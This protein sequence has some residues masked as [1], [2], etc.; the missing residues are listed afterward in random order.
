VTSGAWRSH[1]RLATAARAFALLAITAPVLWE[2]HAEALPFLGSLA[3]VWLLGV[4]AQHRLRSW[5]GSLDLVEAALIGVIAGFALPIAPGLVAALALPPFLS[6]LRHGP[7]GAAEALA[8]ELVALVGVS[9]L[10]AGGLNSSQGMGVFT[11]T[12]TGLGLGLVAGFVHST[13]RVEQDALTPYRDA[14][15]LILELLDLSGGLSA[16]LD[17]VSL[18]NEIVRATLDG[19]PAAALAVHVPRGS[20][21]TPLTRTITDSRAQLD[22][23]DL[24]AQAVLRDGLTRV[25]GQDFAFAL[26]PPAAPVAVVSGVLPS[27]LLPDRIGLRDRIAEHTQRLT[28]TTTRLDTALLFAAFRDSAT[29]DERRRLAREM[30]DG[31]AQDI[32]S[33][34]YLVDALAASPASPAQAEQL[35]LL[36]DSITTVVAEV[37]RSVLTL[38]S[39]VEGSASLGSAIGGLA[40]HLSALSGVPIKVTVDEGTTRLRPEVEA[41]LLR[42]AQESL[43]N[44]VRHAEAYLI[45]VTCLVNPPEVALIISDNG[46]GLQGRRSDSHGLEIMGERARL[47]GAHLQIGNRSEGGT[48]VSVRLAADEHISTAADVALSQKVSVA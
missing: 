14:R 26:G 40:R 21:V 39:S 24:L 13:T 15:A 6:G 36:R 9:T 46:R 4:V 23:S 12:V 3:A 33:M 20:E 10:F 8:A 42:I 22:S 19:I 17:P 31:V 27:G 32:A 38:R 45:N 44:A 30:H 2:R 28:A 7:R 47:I 48:E 18:G 16:G 25:E 5:A 1:A 37:R 35:Q 29:T 43:N 11:W 41:E 34:G